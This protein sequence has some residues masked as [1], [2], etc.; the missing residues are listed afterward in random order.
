MFFDCFSSLGLGQL[1]ALEENLNSVAYIE[2]LKEH[3]IPGIKAAGIPI[4]FKPFHGYLNRQISTQLIKKNFSIPKTRE[5]TEFIIKENMT[6]IFNSR[7][8]KIL[9]DKLLK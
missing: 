4:I 3:L 2:L 5:N 6:V 8:L 7:R 1:V 9:L